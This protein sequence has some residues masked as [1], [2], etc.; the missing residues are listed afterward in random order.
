[1]KTPQDVQKEYPEYDNLVANLK[2]T[3]KQMIEYKKLMHQI[4]FDK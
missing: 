2:Q 1:M 3:N 4:A